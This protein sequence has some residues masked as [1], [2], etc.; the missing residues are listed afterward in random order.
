MKVE[1]IQ[2]GHNLDY[3]NT[4]E[5]LITAGE[6]VIIGEICAI[7]ACTIPPGEKGVVSTN[8]VWLMPKDDAEISAGAKV[9][10]DSDADEISATEG[11]NTFV[12]IAV[13]AA[14][15]GDTSAAVRLNG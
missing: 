6:L 13:A 15:A 12:G 9:Y 8:G 10:Y 11:S 14:A 4:G 2:T 7:A 5:T 1:Y 3:V